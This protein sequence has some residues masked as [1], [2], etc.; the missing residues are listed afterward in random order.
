MTKFYFCLIFLAGLLQQNSNLSAQSIKTIVYKDGRFDI[1]GSTVKISNCYPA[2]DNQSLKPLR[3]KIAEANNTKTIQYFLL[4]GMLTLT[5]SYND[6]ELAVNTF[7]SGK[8]IVP[9]II[10]IIH[11][12]EVTGADKVYR[13]PVIISGNGGVKNWPK[14]DKRDSE[15][16]A[17]TGL[18]PNDNGYSMVISTRDY[19]KYVSY[20][21]LHP[22]E[23]ND[24]KKRIDLSIKT[25]NVAY[26]NIPA[27]YFTEN[28]SV[29]DAM[30][31]EAKASAQFMGV[32]ND[33]PQS[34]HWCSW[35]FSYYHLTAAMVS[36]YLRGFKNVEP[37]VNIQT[38]QIDAG[39]HPHVGDWLEPSFKFPNGIE[40]SV[41]EI[42]A[43]KYKAGIWIG[44][45]MVGNRSKLYTE[46]PDWL[47][48]R[49][50]GT[51]IVQMKFYGEERL[52]GSIDEEYF[53]LDT[54]N[55]NVMEY[56]RNVFRTFR[57]M[58]I[59]FFKTDFMYYGWESSNNV[60]RHTPGKTS[61]EYQRDLFDMI[62]QEIGP[63]SY[64]LGCIAPFPVMLGYVD[65]MRISGDINPNW[66][67]C[68][69]M[70]DETKGDQHINNVWWQNDPDA[71]TLRSQYSNLTDEET[72]SVTLWVG[73]TGG[74]INTS[75]LFHEI[76]KERLDLFRF[77][78]PGSTKLTSHLPFINKGSEL[79]VLVREFPSK[80]SWAV[81]FVNRKDEKVAESFSLK[82]LIGSDNATCFDWNV[83]TFE[84]T[85]SSS[86]IGIQ[87][88]PHH[89]K[90]IF[91]SI[92]GKSPEGMK[93]NGE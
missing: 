25:E 60:K 37:P 26:N 36:D 65:G 52:W 84:K 7:L 20:T 43:N 29:Y 73:M 85:D 83:S 87:L 21:Y 51:P 55:P 6:N 39:Y 44:P 3:V 70:F 90:L 40:P 2:L 16:H 57:K 61:S 12:A 80:K 28:I 41:K 17:I 47:L 27:F 48:R 11:S 75:D 9:G 8:K 34:Y 77:L 88:P 14:N 35:Y 71:L 42:I 30:R 54:S 50:D 63:E 38:F 67:G 89:S 53:V 62:R 23:L 76:P 13:T 32:K 79:E 72:K 68:A 59:T 81:L 91:I 49:N 33:K 58:G 31:N 45:Y 86:S 78:E 19:K 69:N 4:E 18:L 46:H 5:L 64:W 66:Q 1:I 56:L 22:T 82:S 74:V 10:S 93:L 92:E 24:G 15:C